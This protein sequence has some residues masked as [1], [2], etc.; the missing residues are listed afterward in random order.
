MK[1]LNIIVVGAG[2]YTCGRGTDGYG[3]IMPAIFEWAKNKKVG[4]IYLAATAPKSIK[5]AKAKINGLSK[6]MKLKIKVSYFPN[7]AKADKK[8]Y[9]RAMKEIARPGIAIVAVPDDLHGEVAGEAIKHGLH[10]LVVKPLTPTVKEA[11]K[12]IVLQKK[13]K[14]H[15][16]VEFHK[17][18]DLANIKLKNTIEDGALGDLLYFV[19]EFS[20][21]KSI[22]SKS[23]AKWSSRTN[24]FQYLGVHYVD[25]IRFATKAKPVRVSAV[26][27][28]NWLYAKGINTYDSICGVIE[29][30]TAKGKKFVSH[31][32]TN[33]IDPENTS[34]TSDQKIKVVGTKGRFESD[35]KRRGIMIVTDKSGVVEPNPYFSAAYRVNGD[36]SYRGYGIESICRFLD[37]VIQIE[38]NTTK[39]ND[40]EGNRPTFKEAIASTAVI[41][42]INK[43]LTKK[44]KWITVRKDIQ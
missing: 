14:V 23:F 41:E 29:W 11:E 22:P 26:G 13:A 42:A 9:L 40:L 3:T 20:Q 15:C 36:V 38:E 31:I 33:W 30:K 28:K 4:D 39:I 35:Q 24:I 19:A 44:G 25:I 21:R 34:A 8:A 7:S 16:A 2:M 12:L 32:L 18:F 5:K 37:D 17:R 43:S 27:E 1:L 10:T 6:A